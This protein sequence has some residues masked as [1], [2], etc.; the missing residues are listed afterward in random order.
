MGRSFITSC[1]LV[2]L[3]GCWDQAEI[4]LDVTRDE[5][6]LNLD[7]LVCDTSGMSCNA[8]NDA[9]PA[10]FG[11]EIAFKRR[12]SIFTKQS[13]VLLRLQA[14]SMTNDLLCVDLS[15]TS[16]LERDIVVHQTLLTWCATTDNCE[17]PLSMCP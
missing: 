17:T 14:Q 13:H 1:A 11:D 16:K 9:S 3:A 7:I 12:V 15:P 6:G 5:V 4:Q 10:I 2:A 8:A